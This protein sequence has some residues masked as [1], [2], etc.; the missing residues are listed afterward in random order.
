MR[1]DKVIPS[2]NGIRAV[3]I[4]LVLGSHTKFAPNFSKD[5]IYIWNHFFNGALGVTIFF[6]LSG[7]LI[8][9][10]LIK[11]KDKTQTISLTNFYLRR[12]LRIFPVYYCLLFVYFLLQLAGILKF[13][14]H[15][16][17][18]SLTYT[19]D[20]AF[21]NWEDSHLWSL[22]VEEQ[23]YLAWPLVFKYA[24]KNKKVLISFIIVAACPL[25]R[26]LGYLFQ[27]TEFLKFSLFANIDS[28]MIG[29][30]AAIYLPLIVNIMRNYSQNAI[31]ILATA[32][33][34]FVWY[35]ELHKIVDPLVVP[36]G[37]TITGL[38]ASLLIVSLGFFQGGIGYALLNTKLFNYIGILSYSIYIWQ[39]IFFSSK[40]IPLSMLPYNFLFI[41]ITAVI[42]YH[43]IE[44]P[45]LNLKSRFT[46]RRSKRVTWVP[47]PALNLE[48]SQ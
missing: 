12:V 41:I 2:L 27:K 23:F 15:Q 44:R 38:C 25:I 28:L 18:T 4:V 42:S 24:L 26:L 43:L 30:L 10:L 17:F 5:F 19:K 22:A 37:R 16:W 48:K 14:I 39:Q 33:I 20:F 1:S 21:R 8:T 40:L 9:H 3:C 11:E 6:V 45:V 29:C 7:F 46:V 31:R 34:I 13:S 36:L 35:L 47:I 32:T